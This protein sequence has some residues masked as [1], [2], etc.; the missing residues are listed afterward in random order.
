MMSDPPI[1]QEE[2]NNMIDQQTRLFKRNMEYNAKLELGGFFW[3]GFML[4]IGKEAPAIQ[5]RHANW[6]DYSFRCM[7]ARVEYERIIKS[8]A[9]KQSQSFDGK[10]EE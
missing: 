5:C 6:M 8:N 4:W 9:K 3:R 2:W 1:S 7:D 10:E